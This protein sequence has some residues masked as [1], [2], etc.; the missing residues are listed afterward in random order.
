MIT[1]YALWAVFLMLQNAAFTLVSRARNSGSYGFHAVA[2]VASNG[3]FIASQ[4]ISLAILMD[5]I[6]NGSWAETFGVG[7][8]YTACTVAGS[9]GMHWVSVTYLENGRRKV[10]A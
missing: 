5:V 9:V 6:K 8:F 2:S 10:G 7:I 4:F 1:T 3:V